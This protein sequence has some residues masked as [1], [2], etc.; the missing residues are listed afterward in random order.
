[1]AD[2]TFTEGEAYALVA[3]AVQRETAAVTEK[4][5]ELEATLAETQA[6]NDILETEKAA[7]VSLA[8]S[9]I[10]EFEDYKAEQE[11]VKAEAES[12]AVRLGE[13]AELNPNLDLTKDGRGDRIVAMS[14]DAYGL[15]LDTL[16]ESAAMNAHAWKAGGSGDAGDCAICGNAKGNALHTGKQTAAAQTVIPRESAAFRGGPIDDKG[17]STSP[18]VKGLF[19]ARRTAVT[20]S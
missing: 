8:E 7:A 18:S 4:V 10:K 16:R 1:M 6:K 2:R 5:T 19:G 3:D 12:R 9:A 17:G 13:V 14:D 11:R 20:K 15:Y